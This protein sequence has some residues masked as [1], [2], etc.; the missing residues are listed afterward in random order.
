MRYEHRMVE[1]NGH[2][3]HMV[4]AGPRN[5][6]LVLMLHGFPEF[7]YGFRHQINQLAEAGYYVVV[8]DQ[9]GYNKSD[10]PQK[11]ESYTLDQLR[12]DCEAFIDV[13]D[14]EQ[15]AV[16][17]HDW[18]GAVAWHLAATRP[19]RVKRLFAINIPHPAD[20]PKIFMKKPTQI[21]RSAYMMFFQL[22]KVPEKL[23]A[24]N[25]FK[26]M[27][28]GLSLTSKEGAFANDDLKR[29]QSA[30]L[31]PGAITGML[32]WY[33]ALRIQMRRGFDE[34][35][36]HV[37]VPTTILWG[38]QDP[39]LSKRLARESAKRCK[40]VDVVFVADATH[41]VHHEEPEIINYLILKKLKNE[42]QG[43]KPI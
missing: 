10:K 20:M 28:K 22:P 1:A 13:F 7:W 19:E 41:W 37:N 32:N 42:K 21:I 38:M 24:T 2:T 36:L 4:C 27:A 23:L 40:E 34:I 6:D 30:W 33:R 5:G 15:A 25:H 3:F 35:D 16:I 8:P 17:G 12:D 14:R 11:I 29:Y 39:F 9:R 18:G 43:I 26:Y 31:K